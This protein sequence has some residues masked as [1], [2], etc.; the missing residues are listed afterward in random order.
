MSALQSALG[1]QLTDEAETIHSSLQIATVAEVVIAMAATIGLIYLL[2]LVL[3]TILAS[4]LIA[5]SLEPVVSWFALLRVPRWIGALIAVGLTVA[6]VGGIAYFSYNQA[7]GFVDQLPTYSARVRSSLENLRRRSE[8]LANPGESA[9][10]KPTEQPKPFVEPSRIAQ[11]LLERGGTIA[12]LLL[13]AA[14][15]PFLV[16]FMLVS[17][18]QS[19]LA[20]VRLFPKNLRLAAHRTVATISNMIRSYIVA[21]VLLGVANAVILSFVFWFLGIRYFYFLGAIS[22]FASLIPYLGVVLAILP[23]LASHAGSLDSSAI[24]AIVVSV[25]GLHVIEMNVVYPKIVGAQLKLN[26][27]PVSLSLLFWSW[28]WGAPGLILAIPLLG[29]LKIICDHIE[30]LSGLGEWLGEPSRP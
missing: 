23:P 13:A 4:L 21:N 16:F 11:M 27:L 14:F 18:D 22:G 8:Q 30:P 5:Y 29:V 24:L 2:K 20:A 28:I 25:I 17:K 10:P 7:V 3:V 1:E 26:P 15:V 19:H 9:V 6:L 12:E